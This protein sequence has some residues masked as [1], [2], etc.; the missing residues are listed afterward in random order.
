MIVSGKFYKLENNN[1]LSLGVYLL[2]GEEYT[3]ENNII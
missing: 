1:Y 3:D 2:N